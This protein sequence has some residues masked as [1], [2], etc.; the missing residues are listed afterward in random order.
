MITLSGTVD[1]QYQRKAAERA[2]VALPGVSGVHNTITV[3]PPFVVSPAEAK[4]AITA[5][6]V[7]H[8]QVDA[9]RV[10]VAIEGSVVRLRGT[11]SSWA[12]RRQVEYAAF[13][14]P[15]VTHVNN[16]LRVIT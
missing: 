2:V 3:T 4:A 13:S 14:A 10:T 1:W 9:Q 11:V 8:A 16:Q 7:R 12:E 15:G 6:L 5:A